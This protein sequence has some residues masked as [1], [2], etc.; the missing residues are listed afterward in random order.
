MRLLRLLTLLLAASLASVA[1]LAIAAPFRRARPARQG[2]T[3]CGDPTPSCRASRCSWASSS[4]HEKEWHTYWQ[5]PG[6]SGLPTRIEWQLP[7]GFTAGPIDWPYPHRLP[8]GPLVNFGYEGETLLLT[9]VQVP[10]NLAT[11]KTVTLTAKAEWLECK[12]V[13]IPGSAD[14]S[15]TLPVRPAAAASSHAALFARSHAQLVPGTVAGVYGARHD[16][17]RPH[18][19]GVGD[20][21]RPQDRHARVLSAGG[22]PHRTC[23]RAGSEP[24]RRQ[25]ALSDCSEAGEGRCQIA[26]R[27]ARRQRRA[28]QGRGLDRD[29][30]GAAR[31]RRRQRRAGDL[32]RPPPRADDVAARGARR[33]VRRR[34][35]PEPDA[36]RVPG[37][38][39]EA[40]RAGAAPHPQRA[41]GRARRR[42]RRR[43]GPV[44]RSAGRPADRPADRRAA[45]WAGA[46]SCRRPG[47]SPL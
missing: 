47:S 25:C 22:R 37:A 30:R 5:V 23:R 9:R 6:D 15:L 24:Q 27:R 11:G 45:R 14:L 13:C 28:G 33:G 43:R 35:D 32:P 44:V 19:A 18:P 17:W 40:D 36:V 21:G 34:L 2:G 26:L 8:A 42:V 10:A 12:D 31:G 3:G 1:H 46:S 39:A 38:V 4:A 20:S 29:G 16:R 7:A 41:D